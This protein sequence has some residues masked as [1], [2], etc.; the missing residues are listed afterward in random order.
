MV[1]WEGI[2]D[3]GPIPTRVWLSRTKLDNENEVNH[4]EWKPLRKV[5]STLQSGVRYCFLSNFPFAVTN[6]STKHLP[7]PVTFSVAHNAFFLLRFNRWTAR[8]WTTNNLVV[9]NMV[10]IRYWLKRG[11]R[12][13]IPILE[14]SEL[15]L[16][17]DHCGNLRVVPG[18][19]SPTRRKTPKQGRSNP[20]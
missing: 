20:F 1:K 13:P 4:E 3:N 11:D 14:S 19:W 9:S 2:E 10:P 16:F 5:R 12:P 15:T 17:P 8:Y 6:N 18:S 7:Y